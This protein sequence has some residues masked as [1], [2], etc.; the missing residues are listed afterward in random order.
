MVDIG[1]SML[2]TLLKFSGVSNVEQLEAFCN[3]YNYSVNVVLSDMIK[4]YLDAVG[5][6]E[7]QKAEEQ[8]GVK[9]KIIVG[10]NV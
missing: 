10:V 8:L 5:K 6:F 4:T 9:P 2:L 3:R 1:G 7:Q